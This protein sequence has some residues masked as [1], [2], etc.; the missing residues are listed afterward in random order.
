MK[1]SHALRALLCLLA[2][3]VLVAPA[4]A[5]RCCD[6]ALLGSPVEA[7][8]GEE[9]RIE[10][11]ILLAYG[12]PGGDVVIPEG[13]RAVS[14]Y[15]FYDNETIT[16]I[17]YPEGIEVAGGASG[18]VNLTRVVIPE[19]ATFLGISAFQD[20][21][22][23]T[24]V[25]LPASLQEI[26]N[27]AFSGCTALET[28]DLPDGLLLIGMSAF[29]GCS[30][31]QAVDIPDSVQF[32]DH[33][34]FR[35]CSAL[36]DV[37]LLSTVLTATDGRSYV[38]SGTPWAETHVVTVQEPFPTAGG[39]IWEIETVEPET[40]VTADGDFLLRGTV[41]VG[42]TG[43]GGGV[44]IPDGVTAIGMDAFAGN[45]AITSLTVP[46]SLRVIGAG[47]FRDCT[48]L[49]RIS[50]AIT[51]DL[52]AILTDAF[53]G[54]TALTELDLPLSAVS[55]TA[56]GGTVFEGTG[57][58]PY[59]LEDAFAPVRTYGGQFADVAEDAWYAQVVAR[60][61]ESGVIDGVTETRYDPEGNVTVAQAV[62]LTAAI[63]ARGTGFEDRLTETDPWYQT[64]YDF[65]ER[66][67]SFVPAEWDDPSRPATRAELAY[68]A[69][70]S[71]PYDQWPNGSWSSSS[72]FPDLYD[73][74]GLAT[75]DYVS[76]VLDMYHA[77]IVSGYAD[78]TYRPND[79]VTRGEAAAIFARVMYPEN[80]LI[81]R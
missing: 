49:T 78:G 29:E 24:D 53:Y 47:A 21:T 8:P 9:F 30:A 32:I 64:Y 66:Y 80:R 55:Y 65:L 59:L 75:T 79:P 23:L 63:L 20:C 28:I 10:D 73:E 1:R 52:W 12:G 56:F 4:G 2:A 36:A 38:F 19:G 31:L 25:T 40:P 62:K 71:L 7:A 69:S 35:S 58:L 39:G 22:A 6:A 37:R 43:D 57:G 26:G 77:G 54:C 67:T 3:A 45:D 81:A 34:A 17:T 16:S 44:V 13:V 11:G 51:D 76:Y 72:N 33:F 68:L 50:P 42:Y 27:M 46:G 5:I 15:A 70:L 60:A 41:V 61:Y 18:C 74:T 48:H 14:I